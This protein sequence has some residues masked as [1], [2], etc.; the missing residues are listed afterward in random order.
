MKKEDIANFR[1]KMEIKRYAQKTIKTYVSH[2]LLFF[3]YIQK[4]PKTV[5]NTDLEQYIYHCIKEQNIAFSTQK[6][7]VGAVKLFYA[8]C[9]D[10]NLNIDYIYPDRQEHKLPNV[11]SQK[12]VQKLLLPLQNLKH[13][14]L[15]S[16]VYS[17][18]LRVSEV[19][20][21]QI[22]DI[23]SSRM[24]IRIKGSKNNRDR[25][26]MLSEKILILLRKYFSKYHPKDY[27]FEG[28]KEGIYSS[29]SVQKIF[30]NALKKSGITK[31]VSTHSLRHSFATHLIENGTD[32]R[33]VQEL[34]GHKNI[35]TTQI[36]THIT[37]A[38]KSKIKSPFDSLL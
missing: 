34:L 24:I 38:T 29:R 6:G 22:S 1:Q 11:L 35:Q 16:V 17:A 37:R 28:Q 18:G 31:N 27:L 7:I 23:D 10:K 15:L 8:L 2:V 19:L 30:K 14:A 26:V 9:H 5:F 4:S 33:I 25:E 12:E 32:I 20:N 13:K 3:N 36:Y 21:L